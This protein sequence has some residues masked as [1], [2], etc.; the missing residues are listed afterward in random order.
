[1][2]IK[3]LNRILLSSFKGKIHNKID[4]DIRRSHTLP[5]KGP[6][7][8]LFFGTD[9][10][11][12]ESL[13]TLHKIY[14]TKVLQRLEVVTVANAKEN[15]VTKYAKENRITLNK[16]PTEES[17]SDFHIGVVVSFGH[18]IPSK[19]INSFPLGMLNVHGSLLPRWRGAAPL[20][21]TLMNGELQ[22]GI[23]IMKI[24][25]KKFDTGPIV[26]QRQVNIS[27]DETLP[28]LTSKLAKIGANLLGETFDNLP[29]LIQSA[30]PQ[31]EKYVTYAP[32]ITPKISIINWNEMSA[33]RIYDL[34]RAL[35]GLYPLTAF[36]QDLK[37]RLLDVKKIEA[38]SLGTLI[39]KLE[40][41]MPGTVV[42][43]KKKDALIVKCKDESFIAVKKVIIEGKR[44]ISAN[45]FRNG[46]IA[47]KRKKKECFS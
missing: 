19:I 7:K 6:W 26:L 4:T 14:E 34:H 17:I 35:L 46:F 28:E 18:L 13:K 44:C 37:I 36:F 1:M 31:D 39:T 10:F 40:G 21:Y 2:Y 16:W 45:D 47:A 25:P 20:P 3:K 9:E 12:V 15:A 41:E 11:A 42:Y 5:Q 8:V 27:E 30:K 43:D 22:T 32:K 23:T 33:K 29:E 24:M 38:T